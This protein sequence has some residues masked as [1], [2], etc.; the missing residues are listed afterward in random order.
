MEASADYFGDRVDSFDRNASRKWDDPV[1]NQYF[2]VLMNYMGINRRTVLIDRHTGPQV[3]N[4]PLAGYRF[5]QPKPQDYLG[6][7]PSAP[8]VYRIRMTSPLW[9]MEDNVPPG[10][11]SPEF[12][13]QTNSMIKSRTLSMELWLDGPVEFNTAGKIIKSGDIVIARDG[14]FLVGGRWMGG[15]TTQGHPDYMWVPYSILKPDPQ[16]EV[17]HANVYI[18]IDW[19]RRH[20]LSG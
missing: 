4:Q 19:I 15:N 14:E 2:L 6:A 20:I 10:A 3:W 18:D 16:S 9:W 11:L 7:D 8:N 17:K 5:E 1:P 13:F 12:N